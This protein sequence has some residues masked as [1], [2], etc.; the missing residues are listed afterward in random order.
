M[1]IIKYNLAV[2]AM[3]I[4]RMLRASLSTYVKLNAEN[5]ARR[6]LKPLLGIDDVGTSNLFKN[7]L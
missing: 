4:K 5:N 2:A 6:P 7:V 3:P 1:L